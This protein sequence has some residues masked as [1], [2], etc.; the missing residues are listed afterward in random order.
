MV[1]FL[2][3]VGVGVLSVLVILISYGCAAAAVLSGQLKG[4]PRPSGP[5]PL[6]DG[7]DPLPRLWSLHVHA[8]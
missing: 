4:G 3:G 1:T 6:T 8:T 5:V 2:V 7:W